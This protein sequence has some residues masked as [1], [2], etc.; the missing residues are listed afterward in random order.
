MKLEDIFSLRI[1]GVLWDY[2]KEYRAAFKKQNWAFVLKVTEDISVSITLGPT[3]YSTPRAFIADLNDYTQLE[4]GFL[5]NSDWLCCKKY[6]DQ[7]D[8]K[9]FELDQEL[10]ICPYISIDDA[11]NL[12]NKVIARSRK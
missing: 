2:E 4:I 10:H 12:I 6:I 3:S 5:Q 7:E 8:F 11:Y 9:F 1:D